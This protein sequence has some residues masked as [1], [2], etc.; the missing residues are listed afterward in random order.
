[1]RGV[2]RDCVRYIPLTKQDASGQ[3]M[4]YNGMA[5]T[6]PVGKKFDQQQPLAGARFVYRCCVHM[7]RGGATDGCPVLLVGSCSTLP[8]PAM[9]SQH[10]QHSTGQRRSEPPRRTFAAAASCF[11][12]RSCR[13]VLRRGATAAVAAPAGC[14]LRYWGLGTWPWKPACSSST[15]TTVG[16]NTTSLG[17]GTL[18]QLLTAEGLLLHPPRLCGRMQA[19]VCDRLSGV[20]ETGEGAEASTPEQLQRPKN[21]ETAQAADAPCRAGEGPGNAGLV[22]LLASPVASLR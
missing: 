5:N 9:Q 1:V 8:T 20:H 17:S 7:Q 14:P 18:A 11:C 15:P 4:V 22:A 19:R 10:F 21:D 12:A 16:S 13:R 3:L 2:E 6:S